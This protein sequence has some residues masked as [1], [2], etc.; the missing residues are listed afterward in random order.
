MEYEE[1]FIR[2]SMNK[3]S[4]VHRDITGLINLN[5]TSRHHILSI[6]KRLDPECDTIHKIL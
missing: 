4:Y 6:M 3:E 1:C 5:D 2:V